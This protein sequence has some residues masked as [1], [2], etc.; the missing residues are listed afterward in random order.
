MVSD[1]QARRDQAA[2]GGQDRWVAV[3]REAGCDSAFKLGEFLTCR[4]EFFYLGSDHS[5]GSHPVPNHRQRLRTVWPTLRGNYRSEPP[6]GVRP[7]NVNPDDKRR[8]EATRG[9]PCSRRPRSSDTA[10]R[11]A[12]AAGWQSRS[13]IAPFWGPAQRPL[14]SWSILEARHRASAARRLL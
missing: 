3:I 14:A 12:A 10:R 1:Y 8:P 6:D 5:I 4:R 2:S 13:S 9:F 11:P 7:K